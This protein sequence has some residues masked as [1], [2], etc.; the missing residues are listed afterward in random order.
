MGLQQ[1]GQNHCFINRRL[2]V[3]ELTT[4]SADAGVSLLLTDDGYTAE[5]DVANKLNFRNYQQNNR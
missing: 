2:L 1:L 5:L 4:E 3:A